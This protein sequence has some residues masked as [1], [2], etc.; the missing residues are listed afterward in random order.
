ME[1]FNVL[2]QVLRVL[3]ENECVDEQFIQSKQIFQKVYVKKD[4]N[5]QKI[6]NIRIPASYKSGITF[7]SFKG[8]DLMKEILSEKEMHIHL[9]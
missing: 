1:K 3:V 2:G 4:K 8:S 7:F 9:Q 5:E 6:S